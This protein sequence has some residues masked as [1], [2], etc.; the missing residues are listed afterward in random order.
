MPR[1]PSRST[2][3]TDRDPDAGKRTLEAEHCDPQVR[4]PFIAALAAAFAGRLT[5][6]PGLPLAL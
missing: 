5:L 3:R 6:L 2:A 4:E 1:V